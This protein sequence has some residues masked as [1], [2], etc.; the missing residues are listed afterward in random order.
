[1]AKESRKKRWNKKS[2][3]FH[4][5]QISSVHMYLCC[6]CQEEKKKNT[7]LS[8]YGKEKGTVQS[9]AISGA[10]AQLQAMPHLLQC[11]SGES[12]G[13]GDEHGNDNALCIN[14]TSPAA[15][16]GAQPVFMP[17]APV[18]CTDGTMYES[19]AAYVASMPPKNCHVVSDERFQRFVRILN[20]ESAPDGSLAQLKRCTYM[21]LSSANRC[22]P[23][24]RHL[25]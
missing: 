20:G 5:A 9:S 6:S 19:F 11:S 4:N 8:D 17:L 24:K 16:E 2:S 10:I 15:E 3:V 21:P 7:I 18:V 25:S 13:S 1:M 12:S 23:A 22:D 14:D